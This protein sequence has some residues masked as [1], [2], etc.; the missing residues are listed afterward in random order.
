[1]RLLI[2]AAAALLT[3]SLVACAG[4]NAAD[5]DVEEPIP[6][7]GGFT[8]TLH[9]RVMAGQGS[10]VVGVPLEGVKITV[11]YGEQTLGPIVT[12]A[13]GSMS[14]PALSLFPDGTVDDP[15]AL[16]AVDPVNAE[17]HFEMDGYRPTVEIVT[18]PVDR[19]REFTFYL[20]GEGS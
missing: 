13:S 10:G 5:T 6:Q 7:E 12:D 2:G 20:K 14:I 4:R 8:T 17:V 3:V 1:M 9:G 15:A 19:Y 18:F 11:H 16:E